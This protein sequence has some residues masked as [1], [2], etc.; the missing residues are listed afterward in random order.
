VKVDQKAIRV[1]TLGCSKNVVDSEALLAHLKRADR[2]LVEDDEDAGTIIINT[3]GFIEA[4]KQESIDAIIEAVE[5][6]KRGEVGRVVVMG[7]L[8]ERFREELRREIPE[9][10]SF[11][12]SNDLPRV[13]ADLG[14]DYRKE[15]LGERF[16]TT[17]SHFAYL[18]ISE[19]CD[20]PCSFCA[21]PLMRGGHRSKPL[22][23][24]V[25]EASLL[26]AKGVREL[27]I[28][29]Q[30]TTSYGIDTGGD[31]RLA[32]VLRAV[33][34][35]DGLEWIRLMY[36]YPAK[37]PE[38]V[39]EMFSHSKKLCRYLGYADPAYFRFSPSLD[40]SRYHAARDTRTDRTDPRD[41]PRH[42]VANNLDRW[43]SERNG[44]RFS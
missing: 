9:V 31:E 10:D 43:V 4:A 28:I 16:L 7:C 21:I 22:P 19:G 6:K 41:A 5:Q 8:S 20:R 35:V 38:D 24:I 25:H 15:L 11:F 13:L 23:E 33:E 34:K 32:D 42:G 2:P 27:I 26:A 37:F 14:I 3:C 40:A 30:D 18:K 39:L 36:A 17:P 1:V 44:R 29:A 12:G